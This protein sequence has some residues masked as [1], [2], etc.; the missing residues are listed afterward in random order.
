MLLL[1][2]PCRSNCGIGKS[3]WREATQVAQETR[4]CHGIRGSNRGGRR[5]HGQRLSDTPR[6]QLLRL[7]HFNSNPVHHSA[8][9]CHGKGQAQVRNRG[10]AVIVT[11]HHNI[12]AWRR[13]QRLDEVERG[14]LINL[15]T[16]GETE[17]Q[18]Q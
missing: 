9:L 12:N 8:I 6:H 11:A 10:S 14:T 5:E 3:D 1:V 16:F 13:V 18:S 15:V 7:L 17:F 4:A 2:S